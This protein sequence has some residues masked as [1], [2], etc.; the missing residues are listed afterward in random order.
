[1]FVLEIREVSVSLNVLM[2][3]TSWSIGIPS[4]NNQDE[5]IRVWGFYHV[6]LLHLGGRGGGVQGMDVECV[7]CTSSI[8]DLRGFARGI[9]HA[10]K[11]DGR[12][13]SIPAVFPT[14][15]YEGTNST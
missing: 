7:R 10:I 9:G 2:H 5:K 6:F 11:S 8:S 13:G 3:S 15:V 12:R 4:K 1:M 14:T